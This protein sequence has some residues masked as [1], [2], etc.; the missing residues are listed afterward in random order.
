MGKHGGVRA[1]SGRK[2]KA[3]EMG[4]AALL[5]ECFTDA[6]RKTCIRKLVLDSK[7]STFQIRDAAR[8]LLLAY[9]FGQPAA[10][11]ELTGKDGGPVETTSTI[12]IQGVPGNERK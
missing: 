8:K 10:K 9:T 12:V 11:T 5:N 3:E 6:D 7:S 1:G 2:S 4:L